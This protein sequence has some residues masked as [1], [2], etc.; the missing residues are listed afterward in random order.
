M[1]PELYKTL[2]E[3]R[4]AQ[5][6]LQRQAKFW[7][8]V[9]TLTRA[10]GLLSGTAAFGAITNNNQN[11]T[12]FFGVVFAIFQVIEFTASPGAKS[13][14]ASQQAKLYAAAIAEQSKVSAD[15][16]WQKLLDIRAKDTVTCFEYLRKLAYND[17]AE[18]I[19]QTDAG[20]KLGWSA[21]V[22]GFFA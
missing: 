3:L 7:R 15:G 20:F 22:I 2:F 13:A 19:G 18:E 8:R 10:L 14:E 4:Y 9:D 11:L 17:V 16:L 5:R 6:V 1:E 21:R 12:M